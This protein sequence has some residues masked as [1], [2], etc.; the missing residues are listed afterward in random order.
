MDGL[1]ARSQTH[2]RSL[3][4]MQRRQYT[5]FDDYC[6]TATVHNTGPELTDYLVIAA[7]LFDSQDRVINLS[8]AYEPLLEEVSDGLAHEC[9]SCVD[10]LGIDLTGAR[11]ELRA[12]GR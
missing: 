5:E 8:A 1:Y 12:W 11:H 10:P 3:P 4:G 6:L 2:A 7:V 9:D